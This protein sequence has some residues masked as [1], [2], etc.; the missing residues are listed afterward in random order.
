MLFGRALFVAN[1]KIMLIFKK[2]LNNKQNYY[3]Y[4]E[5]KSYPFNASIVFF[6]KF[7]VFLIRK[8]GNY[9]KTNKKKPGKN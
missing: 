9:Y 3:E 4:C 2:K 6:M 5:E 1:V 7:S 8:Y